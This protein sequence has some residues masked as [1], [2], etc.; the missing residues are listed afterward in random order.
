M[1]ACDQILY[2]LG[3]PW[4]Q[5]LGVRTDDELSEDYPALL[6]RGKGVCVVSLAPE[7]EEAAEPVAAWLA[8][9]TRGEELAAFLFEEDAPLALETAWFLIPGTEGVRPV[10]ARGEIRFDPPAADIR[11]FAASMPEADWL[12]GGLAPYA[13]ACGVYDGGRLMALAGGRLLSGVLDLSFVTHPACRGQG[14]GSAAI[15]AM[16]AAYPRALPLWRSEASNE[17]SLSAAHRMGFTEYLIQE[18]IIIQS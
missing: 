12:R 8:P 16:V 17:A 6:I 3:W 5:R 13:R 18:G 1:Q 9:E 2:F 11:A 4:G 10:P 15:S 7:L 14:F